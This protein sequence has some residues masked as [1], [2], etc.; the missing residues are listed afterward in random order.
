MI[1]FSFGTESCCYPGWSAVVQAI[2]CLSLPSNWDYRCPPP[3]LANFGIFSR[4]RVSPSWPGWS[5][6]PDLVIY[7]WPPKALG[8][9]AQYHSIFQAGVQWHKHSSLQPYPLGLKRS[10]HLGL[11]SSWVHRSAPPHLADFCIMK[12]RSV[13]QAGV[14]WCNL[15]SLQPPLPEFKRFS[16]LSLL[17]SW[18]YRRP[19]PRLANFY[20]FSTDNKLLLCCPGWSAVVQSWLIA[21]STSWV[22]AVLCLSLPI[23]GTAGITGTRHHAWLIFAGSCSVTRAT[24]QWHHLSSLQSPPPRFNWDYRR[25][26][27]HQANFCIFSRD[28]VSPYWPGWSRTPDLMIC[29]PW[30]HKGLG[31]QPSKVLGLQEWAT[32]PNLE[33]SSPCSFYKSTIWGQA[34]WLTPVIPALWEAKAGRSLEV[35]S[36][37]PAWPTWI[38]CNGTISAYCNLHLLSSSDFPDS[39]SEV[40]GI[41][42]GVLL[43]AQAGV[44]QH[45][46]GSLTPPP[47]G[48]KQ[49]SCLSLP[50]AGITGAH[51]HGQLIFCIFSR[52]GVSPCWPGLSQLQT[53]ETRFHHVGEADLELLTSGDPKCQDYRRLT[54]LLSL[55]YNGMIKA[56]CSLNLWGSV[57][58]VAETTES[59]KNSQVWW[60]TAVV[61]AN[62]E[63]EAGGSLELRRLRLQL[64]CSGTILAHCNLHLLGSSNSPA[65]ASPLVGITGARH[66]A[67]TESRCHQ[68]AVQWHNLSSLQPLPPGLKRFFCLSL[69]ALWEAKAGGS[70]EIRSFETSLANMLKPLSAKKYKKISPAC[71]HTPVIPAIQEAE[72]GKL[73]E[74]GRHRLQCA[75][76]VP[77]HSTL[78]EASVVESLSPGVPDQSGQHKDTLSQE[79][80]KTKKH[81]VST[82]TKKLSM[83]GGMHLR[84]G[85][86]PCWTGWS[87]LPT[88]GQPTLAYQSAG[89]T[90]VSHRARL[91]HKYFQSSQGRTQ[92]LALSLRLECSGT[93]QLTATSASQVQDILLSQ[94]PEDPSLQPGAVARACNTS[95]LGGQGEW[96]M[97]SGD[98]D[99][100]GQHGKT[101]S[102]L[103]YKTLAGR[104]D[105]V[106]LLLPR[107]ECNGSTSALR[108]LRLLGSSNSPASAS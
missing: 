1:F 42:D 12:T 65:S 24:V 31:L 59:E 54:W 91:V 33:F 23:T 101:L 14:Q 2:P 73:L 51:H 41:T 68:A 81:P 79:K 35:S 21:T 86:L 11:L 4:D 88:S 50:V 13:A 19:P 30:S 5:L 60:Y 97:R 22:Q 9:Q 103:K 25:P 84:D 15:G 87:Q 32:T 55:E 62:W 104:G 72:A 105:G 10:S 52:D 26:P 38:K 78:W 40:A 7:P 28:G 102:L 95:T 89:I 20:V 57:S 107:L 70:L 94:P 37:G 47:P 108:N 90:G 99:H 96:V 71:W 64:E 76:I 16:C 93:S 67:Q 98:R 49:F 69:P 18:D 29:L 56:H 27:P 34:R 8:L 66:H 100:P 106:S 36:L 83:C 77:F 48:F 46:L 6:T 74:L 39:A 53:S 45:D 92:S 17:N 44:Q 63:A 3:C 82:K 80:T 58:Q 75:Q 43:T 85:F 61:P